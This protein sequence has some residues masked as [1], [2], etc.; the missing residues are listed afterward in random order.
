MQFSEKN[1]GGIELHLDK[2]E[3]E[4]IFKTIRFYI[5]QK[6]DD[7]GITEDIKN[8]SRIMISLHPQEF[9]ENEEIKDQDTSKM[10]EPVAFKDLDATLCDLRLICET[11]EALNESF[12]NNSE[13]FPQFAWTMPIEQLG[14]ITDRACDL[15]ED[16]RLGNK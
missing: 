16:I 2:S 11:F 5:A 8:L 3:R 13:S 12:T 1:N 9:A 7:E 10:K 4:L 14:V 6:A 15:F